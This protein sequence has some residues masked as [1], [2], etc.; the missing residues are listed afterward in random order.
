MSYSKPVLSQGKK[1]LRGFNGPKQPT[2]YQLSEEENEWLEKVP[3]KTLLLF[4]GT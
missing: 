3:D 4:F 1:R 2:P